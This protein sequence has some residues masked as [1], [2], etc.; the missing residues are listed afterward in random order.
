MGRPSS[1]R[2]TVAKLQLCISSLL[3][4]RRYLLLRELAAHSDCRRPVSTP[5]SGMGPE[6]WA[7]TMS[8]SGSSPGCSGYAR[9]AMSP[10]PFR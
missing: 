10:R 3:R 4:R 9:A 2:V 7:H 8:G 5:G 1:P 6:R